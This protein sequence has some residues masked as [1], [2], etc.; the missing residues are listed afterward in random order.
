MEIGAERRLKPMRCR[1]RDGRLS[2]RAP[3]GVFSPVFPSVDRSRFFASADQ[4][5][6]LPTIL[7]VDS[8]VAL[9]RSM[10]SSDEHDRFV[11]RFVRFQDR[12]YA[13]V[14]TLLP[15]RND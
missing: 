1:A 13:Y 7:C 14:V 10:D 11:E 3:F 6:R 4:S 8:A 9:G 2:R 5:G 12:I 15:N